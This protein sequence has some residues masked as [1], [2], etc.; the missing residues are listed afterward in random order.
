MSGPP[1]ADPQSKSAGSGRLGVVLTI[2]AL[3]R[4]AALAA[5]AILAITAAVAGCGSSGSAGVSAGA[6][7]KSICTAILPFQQ[8]FQARAAALH[9]TAPNA[10]QDKSEFQGFLTG[11]ASDTEHVVTRLRAAGTPNVANGKVIGPGIVNAFSQLGGALSNA[12]SQASSLPTSSLAAFKTAAQPVA[13]GISAS[14]N[15]ITSGLAPLKSPALVKT[16][17]SEP[18][19]RSLTTSG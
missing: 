9:L 8:S 16:Q 13:R 3:G 12:A 10:A 15:A 5:I 7:V 4:R 2:R 14:S 18:A 1:R 6:Y 17:Q 11:V 19:C